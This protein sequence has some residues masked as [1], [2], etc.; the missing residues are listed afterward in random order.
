MI[1]VYFELLEDIYLLNAQCTQKSKFTQLLAHSINTY[2][3]QR[4]MEYKKKSLQ[5]NA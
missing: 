1:I 4:N 2:L 5:S 3:N